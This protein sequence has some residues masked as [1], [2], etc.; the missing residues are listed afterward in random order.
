LYELKGI[1]DSVLVFEVGRR[2]MAPF[3]A[4]PSSEKALRVDT[5]SSTQR[6]GLI[7]MVLA[8]LAVMGVLWLGLGRPP[9]PIPEP[10]PAEQTLAEPAPVAPESSGE[11]DAAESDETKRPEGYKSLPEGL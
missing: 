1:D 7:A 10:E 3:E 2:G 9:P 4:P 5:G 8:A 6:F 11:S